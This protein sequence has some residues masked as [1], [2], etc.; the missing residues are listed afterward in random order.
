MTGPVDGA[1]IATSLTVDQLI[2]LNA[3]DEV[4]YTDAGDGRRYAS[5]FNDHVRYI[6]D[7]ETWLVWNGNCW[8]PDVGGLKVLALAAGVTRQLKEEAASLSDEAA[9]DGGGLSPR[10]RQLRH[11]FGTESLDARKRMVK[12]ASLQ[13]NVQVVEEDLDSNR[14]IVVTTGCTVNLLS[15]ECQATK[16]SDLNTR[17]ITVPY[18]PN[19]SSPLFTQYLETFI[20]EQED[21]DVIFAILGTALRGGNVGRLLPMMIGKTT[22]GKSQLVEAMEKLLGR[23]ACSIGSSVFRGNLDDK[24]RPDLVKAMY[25]RVAIAVEASKVWELHGDQIKR[26]TGGDRVPYRQLYQGVSEAIPR[27][28]PIIASN[29]MPRIKGADAALKRRII[30][31]RFDHTIPTGMEDT[32]IKQRFVNDERTLQALLARLVKGARSPMVRDGLRWDLI[33]KKFA[34]ATVDAFGE[35]SHVDEFLLWMREEGHLFDDKLDVPVSQMAKASDLHKHYAA[36]VTTH[37][38]KA[39]KQEEL[40]LKDFNV[41]LRERGWESQKSAGVRWVGKVLASNTVVWNMGL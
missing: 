15:G 35:M 13:P 30:V 16:A 40:S 41:A 1:V 11:A 10:A 31:M 36:W 28:T 2:A 38:D 24:P 23:Y 33:P 26:L 19:A 29:D 6:V 37:G 27:F 4:T 8:E 34:I 3:G 5:L 12:M 22:S 39:D 17:I 21:Q 32:T 25:T 20:P 7:A 14:D 18:D 9:E